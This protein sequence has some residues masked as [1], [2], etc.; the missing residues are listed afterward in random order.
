MAIRLPLLACLM[1]LG[2]NGTAFAASMLGFP[3]KVP[4]GESFALCVGR[5]CKMVQIC[6]IHAPKQGDADFD[7]SRVALVGVLG[8]NL[9]KCNE[10]GGGTPCDG[11]M[12]QDQPVPII[13]S[14]SVGGKDVAQTMV[15]LG[16]ACDDTATSGGA[17]SKDGKGKA[18][19]SK[20]TALH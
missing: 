19:T 18:C 13:V 8:N 17:Y 1:L 12:H 7:K 15:D 4:N 16:M 14:C 20:Q 6:G 9:V 10:L 5:A 11:H 3:D 2:M